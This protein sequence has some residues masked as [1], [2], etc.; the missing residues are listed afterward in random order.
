MKL[1]SPRNTY[2]IRNDLIRSLVSVNTS[3]HHF[4]DGTGNAWLITVEFTDGT[5]RDYYVSKACRNRIMGEF[6][7]FSNCPP[8]NLTKETAT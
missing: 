6:D 2:L 3:T 7:R 8:P 5:K 4:E 1:E